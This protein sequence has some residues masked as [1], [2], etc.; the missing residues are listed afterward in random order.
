MDSAPAGVGGIVQLGA[1]KP[2]LGGER[3]LHG[4]GG[5]GPGHGDTRGASSSSRRD[6]SIRAESQEKEPEKE[7]E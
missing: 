5:E 4:K 3:M 2:N 7:R 6:L 1:L